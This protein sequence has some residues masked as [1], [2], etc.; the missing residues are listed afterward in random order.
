MQLSDI[1][2]RVVQVA[3][4]IVESLTGEEL[5]VV[6]TRSDD[7]ELTAWSPFADPAVLEDVLNGWTDHSVWNAPKTL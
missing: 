1:R 6:V 3:V 5:L 7:G 2:S 4:D